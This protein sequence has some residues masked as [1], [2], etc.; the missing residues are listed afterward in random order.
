M[1]AREL[2][3]NFNIPEK[4]R[5]AWKWLY[6]LSPIEQ[7][8]ML[9]PV[10]ESPDRY[11]VVCVGANDRAKDLVFGVSDPGTAEIEHRA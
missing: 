1:P 5:I 4:V 10:Q 9:L 6:D 8:Q 2:I 11:H 7:E 3:N